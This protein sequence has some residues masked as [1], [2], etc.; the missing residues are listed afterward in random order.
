MLKRKRITLIQARSALAAYRRIPI[1]FIDGD[2]NQAVDLSDQLGIYAYDVYLLAAA[3]HQKCA[4][5]TLDR[6]LIQAA[7]QLGI[8][9]VE[10]G[11]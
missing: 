11:E 10:V 9:V 5:L 3:L 7:R 8:A 2:L 6:G 1:Q 4:L